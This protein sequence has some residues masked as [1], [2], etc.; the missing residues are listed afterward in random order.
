MGTLL[1]LGKATLGKMMCFNVQELADVLVQ[2]DAIHR[3]VIAHNLG[4]N[5]K[6]EF[7]IE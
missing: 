2:I 3:F 5:L 4:K 1:E 7:F 6:S